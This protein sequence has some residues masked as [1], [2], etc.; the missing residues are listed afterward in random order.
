MIRLKEKQT[1]SHIIEGHN[2][3]GTVSEDALL[4]LINDSRDD[5]WKNVLE[6]SV[7]EIITCKRSWFENQRKGYFYLTFPCVSDARALDIGAGSGIISEVMSKRFQEVIALEYNPNFIEF[8]RL[9]FEQEKKT[10][11]RLVRANGLQLPFR[12]NSF[13]LI[14]VNGVLEWLPNF[15]PNQNPYKT[16]INFLKSCL[17]KL[18]NGGN[19]VLAIENRFCFNYFF[20]ATP[21]GDIPFTTVLPRPLANFISKTVS[22]KPYLNYIYSPLGYKRILKK[23]GYHN[24]E[25]FV[26]LP[27]YSNPKTIVPFVRNDLLVNEIMSSCSLPNNRAK[28]ILYIFLLKARLLRYLI[29]SFYV[30]G[31][32]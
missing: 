22:N 17:K 8:M 13:D 11:I 10:N 9:R 26:I 29:N 6:R 15:L 32:K 7:N 12:E 3:F 31:Q 30:V 20:G 27:D 16:Q 19:L 21:H 18:K 25:L 24:A 14:V 5:Y 2:E 28:R 4:R 1:N 23:A